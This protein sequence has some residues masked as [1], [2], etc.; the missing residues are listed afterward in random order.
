[1]AF[2]L[3]LWGFH[4]KPIFLPPKITHFFFQTSLLCSAS[5]SSAR[6]H[7]FILYNL[8]CWKPQAAPFFKEH[9]EQGNKA[10]HPWGSDRN[11]VPLE[12]HLD[13]QCCCFSAFRDKDQGICEWIKPARILYTHML[14]LCRI[15]LNGAWQVSLPEASPGLMDAE[16]EYCFRLT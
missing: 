7:F 15:G 5:Q 2:E 14:T 3:K 8:H 16:W 13:S 9:K 12:F 10:K 11:L 4:S 1:M 6:A